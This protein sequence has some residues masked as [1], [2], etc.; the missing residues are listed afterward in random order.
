MSDKN[1][2]LWESR[3]NDYRTSNKTAR[4]WCEQN[5]ITLSSLKYWITRLNKEQA[6][7][8][9]NPEFALISTNNVNSEIFPSAT[10]SFGMISI[11]IT[12][13]CQ[14]DTIKTIL[15]VLNSYV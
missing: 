15:D 3:V 5:N 7:S 11:D 1:H 6:T 8:F 14:P 13:R 4:L 10:I 9:D 12:D 2:E